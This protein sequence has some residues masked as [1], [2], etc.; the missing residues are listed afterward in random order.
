MSPNHRIR[1]AGPFLRYLASELRIVLD[2]VG[3]A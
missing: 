1:G 2:K 3:E